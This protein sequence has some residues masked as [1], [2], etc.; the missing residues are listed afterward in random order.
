MSDPCITRRRPRD[1]I[2]VKPA[3]NFKLIVPI[4]VSM[5]AFTAIGW[6]STREG[7]WGSGDSSRNHIGKARK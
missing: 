1:I 5:H 2:K 7:S 4:G 3:Y 6:I